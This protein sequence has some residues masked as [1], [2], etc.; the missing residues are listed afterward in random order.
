MAIFIILHQRASALVWTQTQI[1]RHFRQSWS[2]R[3]QLFFW[4]KLCFS[5]QNRQKTKRA[6]LRFASD[7]E[8]EKSRK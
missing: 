7:Y 3:E 4:L 2:C 5:Y 6:A 1:C 8:R